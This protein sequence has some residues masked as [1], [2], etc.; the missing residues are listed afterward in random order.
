MCSSDSSPHSRASVA[1][2][3]CGMH[4]HLIMLHFEPNKL[5]L[6]CSLC[7][8]ATEGWD[9]GQADDGAPAGKQSAGAP[10]AAPHAASTAHERATRVIR[11]ALMVDLTW[12]NTWLAILAVISLIQFLI[13]VRGGVF[14]LSHVS[15]R[16]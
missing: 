11:E 13:R 15:E 4:G 2:F 5:S 12:T 14:R 9:V 16:R 10:R 3:W 7:G 1:Q 6:Q 8:Y